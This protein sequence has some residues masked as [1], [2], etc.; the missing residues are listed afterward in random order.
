[1]NDRDQIC[2]CFSSDYLCFEL[3]LTLPMGYFVSICYRP[4][5]TRFSTILYK[6]IKKL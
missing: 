4:F 1:M 6:N 2:M 3:T 5:P